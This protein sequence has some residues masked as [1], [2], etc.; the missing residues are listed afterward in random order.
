MPSSYTVR[1]G[2]TLARISRAGY[3]EAA[4]WRRIAAANALLRP[5]HLFVGQR[6]QIPPPD[7][8]PPAAS[9]SLAPSTSRLQRAADRTARLVATLAPSLAEVASDLLA[10]CAAAGVRLE[11]TQAL[12]TWEDQDRLYAQGRTAPGAIVTRA[13]AGYSYHNF[14]L[15]FDVVVLDDAGAYVWN[16][17]HSGWV[18]AAA[19]GK[20]LGLAWGGDWKS[21]HD[22]PHFEQRGALRLDRCRELYGEG[23]L[24]AVWRGQ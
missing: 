11:V 8:E 15:A 22:I 20:R 10:E 5:D 13:P 3:G 12:R 16:T 7:S 23:G 14:G 17:R 4:Q 9:S 19:T 21:F 2:D 1:S 18:A 6:L 24:A